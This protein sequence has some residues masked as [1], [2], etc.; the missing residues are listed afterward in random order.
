MPTAVVSGVLN[1]WLAGGSAEAILGM[2]A[3]LSAGVM[4]EAMSTG[5][6]A[7]GAVVS[8]MAYPV[9]VAVAAAVVVD[10]EISAQLASTGGLGSV[11]LGLT[12]A[13]I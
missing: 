10:A 7:L 11:S 4:G 8:P 3:A 5:D 1:S 13:G 9:T 2:D 12:Q 6:G